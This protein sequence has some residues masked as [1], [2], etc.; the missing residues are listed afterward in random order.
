[1]EENNSNKVETNSEANISGSNPSVKKPIS[2]V[3]NFILNLFIILLIILDICFQ[4][5]GF[6][7]SHQTIWLLLIPIELLFL[8]LILI[9]LFKK[10]L[11]MIIKTIIIISI[12]VWS[13]FLFSMYA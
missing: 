8:V 4:F 10:A 13:I 1:M 7:V 3:G 9:D 11:T 5:L 6:I 12:I 2:S